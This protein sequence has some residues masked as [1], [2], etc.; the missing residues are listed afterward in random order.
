MG[1]KQV[2]ILTYRIILQ[3]DAYFSLL[4]SLFHADSDN[5]FSLICFCNI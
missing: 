2:Q 3:F 5:L 1:L 4:K